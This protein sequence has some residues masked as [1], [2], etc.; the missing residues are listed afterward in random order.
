MSYRAYGRRKPNLSLRISKVPTPGVPGSRDILLRSGGKSNAD[1]KA[2]N[3]SRFRTVDLLHKGLTN[4]L[5]LP[6][7]V[8]AQRFK[9]DIRRI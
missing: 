1:S 9:F 5:S 4:S 7:R 8:S 3:G 2:V 6:K